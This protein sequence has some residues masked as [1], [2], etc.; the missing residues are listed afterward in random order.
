MGQVPT[1]QCLGLAVATS[2]WG[3][4]VLSHLYNICV[5][6]TWPFK[7]LCSYTHPSP[8]HLQ[9]H[10][11]QTLT[12][13]ASSDHNLTVL[14]NPPPLDTSYKWE[15]M[16]CVFWRLALHSVFRDYN[17]LCICICVCVCFRCVWM[18]RCACMCKPEADSKISY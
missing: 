13:W 5:L 6:T 17:M 12:L 4:L 15:Y 10:L 16:T 7:Y 1:P 11:L 14:S 9:L 8:E 2:H 3:Y 18:C